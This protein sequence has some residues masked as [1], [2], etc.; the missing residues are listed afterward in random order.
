MRVSRNRHVHFTAMVAGFEV[1]PPIE[2]VTGIA[3]PEGTPTG[4]CT[5]T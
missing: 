4:T 2:I 5:L 3:G 1:D